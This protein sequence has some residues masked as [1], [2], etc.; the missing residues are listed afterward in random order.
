MTLPRV[1]RTTRPERRITVD[2]ESK[3]PIHAQIT[4]QLHTAIESGALPPGSLVENEIDL[5]AAL[6]VSRPTLQKAIAEL[7]K[8]GYLTRKPGRGT[9][10][11]PRSFQ[12][13]MSVGSL[14]D[15]LASNGRHPQTRVLG[16]EEAPIPERLRTRLPADPGPLLLI[17][18]LRIADD[19]PLAILQNWIPRAVA[20]FT[21]DELETQ[22]LYELLRR[23]ALIPHLVEQQIGARLATKS[24]ATVLDSHAGDPLVT[25]QRVAFAED[26]SFIEFGDHAYRAERYHFETV[27]VG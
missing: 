1:S 9:V 12:R 26:A 20:S 27:M 2:R 25:V 17:T 11:L 8:M 10:V 3:T 14:Y 6:G 24:E 16:F 21:P 19:E 18:R 4:A 23:S 5:S 15:D 22:G 13:H 7:V